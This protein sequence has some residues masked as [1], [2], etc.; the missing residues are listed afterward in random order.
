MIHTKKTIIRYKRLHD[1]K[2]FRQLDE[3]VFINY[4]LGYQHLL[5]IKRKYFV[6]S[7]VAH[8]HI[9]H[10]TCFIS[11]FPKC[12]LQLEAC[13]NTSAKKIFSCNQIFFRGGLCANM[14]LHQHGV[15]NLTVSVFLQLWLAIRWLGPDLNYHSLFGTAFF[16]TCNQLTNRNLTML[17]VPGMKKDS[18][19]EW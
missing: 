18:C 5:S 19:P 2:K 1:P 3:V 4:Y 8:H 11:N 9:Y 15:L 17:F 14:R 7:I 13:Q 12:K 6:M 10:F 16:L